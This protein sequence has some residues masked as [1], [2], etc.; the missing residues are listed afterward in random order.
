VLR[1]GTYLTLPDAACA[2]RTPA[3][4]DGPSVLCAQSPHVAACTGDSGGP[5]VAGGRVVGVFSFGMET[6]GEPCG[7]PGPNFFAD[8]SAPGAR[9]WLDAQ[10]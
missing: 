9:A 10:W 5:L 2:R 8:V 6:A 1:R 3:A 7:S 4:V